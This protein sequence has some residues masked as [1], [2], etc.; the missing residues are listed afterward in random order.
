MN[1]TSVPKP[2]PPTI[3]VT[4]THFPAG[5]VRVLGFARQW[6]HVVALTSDVHQRIDAIVARSVTQIGHPPAARPQPGRVAVWV[7][8]IDELAHPALGAAAVVLSASVEL[9]EKVGRRGLLIPA[10]LI[11]PEGRFVA[12]HVRA[13]IR[14]ARHLPP[15]LVV[16]HDDAGWRMLPSG[17]RL[18]AELAV[19][20]LACAAAAVV[21]DAASV[22]EA[23]AWGT[24]CIVDPVSARELHVT[25][26][27]QVLV[28]ESQ[29]DRRRLAW[30][31]SDDPVVAAR[32]SWQGRRLVETAHCPEYSAAMLVRQLGLTPASGQYLPE[33]LAASLAEFDPPPD[34][35]VGAR[36]AAATASLMGRPAGAVTLPSTGRR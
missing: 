9:V 33:R 24:P 27:L 2:G 23:M 15:R 12:P 31:V 11:A 17:E 34:S 3:G 7:D 10:G 6:C 19:T 1:D 29:D 14:A 28:G 16:E 32:L 35:V 22:L 5:L 8:A 30:Q 36:A 13:R 21:T 26:D 4:G 18:D 25:F 20:A